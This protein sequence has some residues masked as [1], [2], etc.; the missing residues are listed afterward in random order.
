M[1]KSSTASNLKSSLRSGDLAVAIPAPETLLRPG[2]DSWVIDTGSGQNLAGIRS[3]T[4]QEKQ[5]LK[6][7]GNPLK[8]S[9]A[10]GIVN[11]TR[12]STADVRELDNIK[13]PLRV[14][15]KTPRVLSVAQLV[16][17]GG[18][19]SWTRAHGAVLTLNGRRHE[20]QIQNGVPLLACAAFQKRN[21]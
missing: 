10:N 13:L 4:D 3:L 8:L 5:A 7:D 21:P 20:L 17:L 9:T 1:L 15:N 14:L 16:E 18:E 19:F 11:D 6:H 2:I 12:I